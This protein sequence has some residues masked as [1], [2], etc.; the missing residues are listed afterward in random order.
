[1]PSAIVIF[2]WL[3]VGLLF[4][5][6]ALLFGGGECGAVERFVAALVAVP[7]VALL[8]ATAVRS[9]C[10]GASATT[11]SSIAMQTTARNAEVAGWHLAWQPV[12][13]VRRRPA[14]PGRRG[15]PC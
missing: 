11:G 7:V 4:G 2:G 6:W 3:A 13:H 5:G 15:R 1:M 14:A 10:T 9:T 12:L 8:V